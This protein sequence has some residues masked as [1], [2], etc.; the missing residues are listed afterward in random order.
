MHKKEKAAFLT[1]DEGHAVIGKDKISR[2][3]FYNALE[4]KQIPS[5]R[6]GRRILIP[7]HAFMDWL[8]QRGAVA[9]E[10]GQ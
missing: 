3:A 10:R 4:R 5:V 6:I 1:A 9:S 8:E 7:R 2:R